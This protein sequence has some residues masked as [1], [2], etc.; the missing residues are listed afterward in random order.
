[1]ELQPFEISAGPREISIRSFESAG[2]TP[3][4]N[5]AP[6]EGGG[7]DPFAQV[8]SRPL[9]NGIRGRSGG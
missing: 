4:P 8:E 2:M 5:R 1:M 3:S 7:P 9:D 6:R